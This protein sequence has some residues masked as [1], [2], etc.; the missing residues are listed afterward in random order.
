MEV[1]QEDFKDEVFDSCERSIGNCEQASAASKQ[2][3][4]EDKDTDT[5]MYISEKGKRRVNGP[6]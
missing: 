6:V 4:I 3:D 2:W 1:L 5:Y